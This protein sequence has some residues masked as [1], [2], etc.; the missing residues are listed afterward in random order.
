MSKLSRIFKLYQKE[1]PGDE[2]IE[3]ML[4]GCEAALKW[5]EEKSRYIVESFK[6]A[7]DRKA[8]DFSPMWS[9]RK[10]KTIMFTSDRAEGLN[11]APYDRTQRG[12]TDV[13]QVKLEGSRGKVKW[14]DPNLVEG[15]NTKWN[16]GT[17]TFNSRRS[18]MYITQ[19]NSE[20]GKVPKCKIYEARKSG[21]GWQMNPEPLSFCNWRK[22]TPNW[23]YW[24]PYLKETK[25]KPCTLTSDRPGGYGDTGALEK[26]RHMDGNIR[27]KRKNME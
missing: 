24:T 17:V 21:R 9:D 19:C 6:P 13:W 15:L 11:K 5:E 26:Q 18:V 20:T 3:T 14:G 25:T 4:Q 23:N 22:R 7:N 10:N 8:D 27:A 1:V 12:F 2:R 16:D